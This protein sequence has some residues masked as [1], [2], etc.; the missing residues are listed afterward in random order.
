M[1][2]FGGPDRGR[3]GDSQ[4]SSPLFS[5]LS[6]SRRVGT[7]SS[8][9]TGAGTVSSP[10]PPSPLLPSGAASRPIPEPHRCAC[11]ACVG[12]GSRGNRTCPLR[13][14][15]PDSHARRCS[16]GPKPLQTERGGSTPR[17]PSTAPDLADSAFAPGSVHGR[18]ARRGPRRC[19]LVA[20]DSLAS[21]AYPLWPL[22]GGW[23]TVGALLYLISLIV[24]Y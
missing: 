21:Q 8:F 13:P 3:P 1:A 9:R 19:A 4:L 16:S 24:H 18:G 6:N 2:L 23:R 22:P 20:L 10:G 14:A 11:R 15:K 12:A 7:F 17:V 5:Q